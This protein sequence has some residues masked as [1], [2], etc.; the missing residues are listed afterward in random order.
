VKK[1]ALQRKEC[2][3]HMT[4]VKKGIRINC[5]VSAY[6]GGANARDIGP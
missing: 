6:T 1:K 5:R 3:A 4:P 2:G